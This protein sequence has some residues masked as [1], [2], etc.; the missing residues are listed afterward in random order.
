V[1]RRYSESADRARS[2]VVVRL[3]RRHDLHPALQRCVAAHAAH[4]QATQV[5]LAEARAAVG[6][7]GPDD[8]AA[9]LSD[10]AE[11]QT[12][13]L[14][15]ILAVAEA[16]PELTADASFAR[17]QRELADTEDRIAASRTFYNDSLTIL[18]DRCQKFPDSLIANRIRLDHRELIEARGFERTVPAVRHAFTHEP[19]SS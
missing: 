11:M 16:H 2:R 18:R 17:L 15:S 10:E 12:Q 7:A 13:A 8:E 9:A 5:S 6:R 3:R 19:S 1:L 14:R 4:E